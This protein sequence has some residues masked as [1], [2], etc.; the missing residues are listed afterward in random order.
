MKLVILVPS[1]VWVLIL[2]VLQ[3]NASDEESIGVIHELPMPAYGGHYSVLSSFMPPVTQPVLLFTRW[4]HFRTFS[5]IFLVF[6][7]GNN[8]RISFFQKWF[9]RIFRKSE[10]RGAL[11]ALHFGGEVLTAFF[12]FFFFLSFYFLFLGVW[13]VGGRHDIHLDFR[14]PRGHIVPRFF[15]VFSVDCIC[16]T[17]GTSFWFEYFGEIEYFE[18]RGGRKAF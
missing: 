11:F 9:E 10:S 5:S 4:I 7:F 1:F 6:H 15:H 16:S 17:L 8:V 12:F 18:G 14:L 13:M 2:I 3:V